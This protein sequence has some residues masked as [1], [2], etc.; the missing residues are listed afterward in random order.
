MKIL[1][2]LDE[3][4]MCDILKLKFCSLQE[5]EISSNILNKDWADGQWHLIA[6][7]QNS[8]GTYKCKN[9]SDIMLLVL[10]IPYSNAECKRIFSYIKKNIY[11]L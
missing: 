6:Q 5:D 2:A 9:K 1:E 4:K 10:T 11:S 8:D 7:L 3:G